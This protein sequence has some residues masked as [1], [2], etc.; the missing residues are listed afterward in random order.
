MEKFL[1]RQ[2][3]LALCRGDAT[4]LVR[5]DC[6][7]KE[8]IDKYDLLQ[9]TLQAHICPTILLKS[10]TWMRAGCPLILVLRRLSP[11]KGQK[12]VHYCVSG[13]KD[14]ITVLGCLNAI[15]QS[16][17]PMVTFEGKHLNHRWTIGELPGTYY[18]MSDKGWTDQELFRHWFKNHFLK[19]AK[20]GRPLLL[21][22][23]GLLG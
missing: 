16:I 10:T 21:L 2:P 19:Y 5:L 18:G 6:T 14:Q 20:C 15:G 12:K 8:A 4:A 23:D 9:E 11:N 3:Q 17:P 22:L 1:E 13:K 7:N